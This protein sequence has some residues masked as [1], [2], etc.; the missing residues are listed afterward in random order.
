M[1]AMKGHL[2]RGGLASY[3]YITLPI[4]AEA[5]VRWEDQGVRHAPKVKLEGIVPDNPVDWNIYFI[6][7]KD[8]SVTVGTAPSSDRA[9]N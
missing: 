3:G 1:A 7:E 9:A 4:P 5:E 8:G 6:I 2:G